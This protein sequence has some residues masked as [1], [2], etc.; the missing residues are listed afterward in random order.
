MSA[1]SPGC[2]AAINVARPIAPTIG[3]LLLLVTEALVK[4]SLRDSE[5]SSAPRSPSISV[6]EFSRLGPFRLG[7]IAFDAKDR[8]ED[9][10]LPLGMR[11]EEGGNLVIL[12]NGSHC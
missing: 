10:I 2:P 9:E 8:H 5:Y 7:R 12:A 6:E 1:S 11:T 3:S 4:R